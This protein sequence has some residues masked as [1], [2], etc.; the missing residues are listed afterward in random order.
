[1]FSVSAPL[2]GQKKRKYIVFSS[3]AMCFAVTISNILVQ[4][5][6]HWFGLNE[7]L[8]YGAFTYPI[9]FLI[10]DLTNRF[11]GPSAARYVVYAGFFSGFFVSWILAT[12]R[13]AIASSSAFLFGQLLDILVFSPLRRKTWWKAP[14]AAG[15]VGSALDTI[16]FFAIAFSSSFAFI[17]QMTGYAN[18]SITE[19][20]VFLG[21]ELPVWFSLAFGDFAIKIIM[22]FLMLIPYG[23]ILSYFNLPL[24]QNH[25]KKVHL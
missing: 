2:P 13:L 23:T 5:P 21:L 12:P 3:L 14:L 8:T 7:L 9:A 11:Y 25:S 4:Y 15:L 18:S 22:S 20:S 17:D 19:N 6:V 24:Y 16:L 10:N 1:M